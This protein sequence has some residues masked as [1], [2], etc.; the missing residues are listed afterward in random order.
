MAK[1]HPFTHQTPNCKRTG[2][3]KKETPKLN[4]RGKLVAE[5]EDPPTIGVS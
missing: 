4:K 1:G 2:K 3:L 5:T